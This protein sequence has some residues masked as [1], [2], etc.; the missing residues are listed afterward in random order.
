MSLYVQYKGSFF[1]EKW[2]IFLGSKNMPKDYP[3]LLHPVHGNEEIPLFE[4]AHQWSFF[5]LFRKVY[6]YIYMPNRDRK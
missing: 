4:L 2:W 3:K 6:L 5:C 1:S